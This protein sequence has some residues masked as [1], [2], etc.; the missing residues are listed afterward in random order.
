ME[1][2]EPAPAWDRIKRRKLSVFTRTNNAMIP[3]DLDPIVEV[4]SGVKTKGDDGISEDVLMV[5]LPG[6]PP[7]IPNLKNL[8]MVHKKLKAI[9]P[10]LQAPRIGKI[11][12]ERNGVVSRAKHHAPVSGV[13]D[14]HIVFSMEKKGCTH[15]NQMAHLK[16]GDV[17][18]NKWPVPG[19]SFSQLLQVPKATVRPGTA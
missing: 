14:D 13:N 5:T 7:N 10:K 8:E 16:G 19:I 18:F 15:K 3:E 17:F 11:E 4:Y 2:V 1:N 6:P 9:T 12:I